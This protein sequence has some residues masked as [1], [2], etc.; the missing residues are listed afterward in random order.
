MKNNVRLGYTPLARQSMGQFPA[1]FT[2]FTTWPSSP[3][4]K[5]VPTSSSKQSQVDLQGQSL[6]VCCLAAMQNRG[7]PKARIRSARGRSI[8]TTQRILTAYN[9]MHFVDQGLSK[10][11][12]A[13]IWQYSTSQHDHQQNITPS[14]K[15][16]PRSPHASP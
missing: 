7:W 11:P 13:S 6:A 12:R 15:P 4:N 1:G 9:E 8:L 10:D 5:T 2:R 3:A 14:H 16:S